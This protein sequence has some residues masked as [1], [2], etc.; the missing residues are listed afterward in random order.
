[1]PVTLRNPNTP[2]TDL[3][4]LN[5]LKSVLHLNLAGLPCT[6][7]AQISASQTGLELTYVQSKY[8]ATLGMTAALPY[9]VH[10]SSGKQHYEKEGAGLRTYVGAFVCILEYMGRWDDQPGSIDAIRKTIAADL[11]RIRANIESN[12]SL[13]FNNTAF[14]VSVPSMQLSDYKGTLNSDYP[15]ITLVERTLTFMINILPYDCLE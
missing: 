9:A 8:Q 15:G 2:N 1:V 14:A 13:Q 3:V 12:D 6:F 10:L 11:E 4:I 5:T 7:L